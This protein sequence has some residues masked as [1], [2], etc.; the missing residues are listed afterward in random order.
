[1]GEECNSRA[2][3]TGKSGD[4]SRGAKAGRQAQNWRA[5][6]EGGLVWEGQV[7]TASAHSQSLG[8]RQAVA[9]AVQYHGTVLEP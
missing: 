9:G 5:A 2:G 6:L 4:S 3:P 8:G 1:M 7:F